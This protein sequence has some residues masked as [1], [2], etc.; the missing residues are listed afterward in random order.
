MIF[1]SEQFYYFYFFCFFA[2]TVNRRAKKK[3][4]PHDISSKLE[5]GDVSEG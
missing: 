3:Y 4:H 5:E 1:Y 2:V